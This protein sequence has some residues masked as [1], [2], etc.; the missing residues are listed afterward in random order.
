M[1][2]IPLQTHSCEQCRRIIFNQRRRDRRSEDRP[3][4][5]V[6]FD[7]TF[8]DLRSGAETRCEL[9][10][11]IINDDCI[12]REPI[13]NQVENDLDKSDPYHGVLEAL[14]DVAVGM[15][16]FLPNSSSTQTLRNLSQRS[17][18]RLNA[19]LLYA[20]TY[21]GSGNVLDIFN[22]EYF[23]LWDPQTQKIAYRMREEFEVFANPNDPASREVSTR[24][25]ES[26][27]GSEDN[28]H[29]VASWLENY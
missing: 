22:I 26:N 20:A 21:Q 8:A 29:K 9:C 17:N 12:P 24:P 1:A 19:L 15:D 7:F 10:M 25:I 11:W 14:R 2:P 13:I 27:P 16:I 28:L 3:D 4:H 6:V 5:G 23:G 18:S